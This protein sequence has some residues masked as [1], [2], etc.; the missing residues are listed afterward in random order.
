MSSSKYMIV[1]AI[2]LWSASA[3]APNIAG[4]EFGENEAPAA[5]RVL[6]EFLEVLGTHIDHINHQ[7]TESIKSL[8]ESPD[9]PN[10]EKQLHWLKTTQETL[11]LLPKDLTQYAIRFDEKMFSS[12]ELSFGFS[13]QPEFFVT[14]FSTPEIANL[15]MGDL[16]STIAS[17]SLKGIFESIKKNIREPFMDVLKELN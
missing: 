13:Q 2:T 15:F 17:P 12:E 4:V 11:P 16:D 6:P 14:Y 7:I 9:T 1:G 8:E 3:F 10:R 5:A